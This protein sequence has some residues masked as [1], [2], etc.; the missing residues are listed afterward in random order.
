[1]HIQD[2]FDQIREADIPILVQR[3]LREGNPLYPVPKIMDAKDCEAV[4]RRLMK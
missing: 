4:L 1:M 2:K 3:A